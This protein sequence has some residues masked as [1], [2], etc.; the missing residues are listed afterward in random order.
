MRKFL[1][2]YKMDIIFY[3]CCA[4]FL[5]QFGKQIYMLVTVDHEDI[6]EISFVNLSEYESEYKDLADEML[7]YFEEVQKERE[8]VLYIECEAYYTGDMQVK[9]YYSDPSLNQEEY[10]PWGENRKEL[11][12]TVKKGTVS[13]R[14]YNGEG[15]GLYIFVSE[16]QVDF[17]FLSCSL[18]YRS[19][20]KKPSMEH[21][22][23]DH[24]SR[25][26]SYGIRWW[27]V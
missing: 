13:P 23:A 11:Y 9:Y 8:D 7:D 17:R 15:G 22:H 10:V 21:V 26:W 3:I 5:T 20:F 16:K 25:S 4:L 12:D 1:R 6:H 18:I 27:L 14:K 24:I 2:Y 19:D